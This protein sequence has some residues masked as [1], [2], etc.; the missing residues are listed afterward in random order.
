M[1]G[2]CKLEMIGLQTGPISNCRAS[3]NPRV[4]KG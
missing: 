1:N 3:Q 2:I 4:P